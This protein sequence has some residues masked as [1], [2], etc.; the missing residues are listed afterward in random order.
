M[1]KSVTAEIISIGDELLYGQI[2]DTNSR[3]ISEELDKIGIRV[4]RRTTVGDDKTTLLEAFGAASKKADIILMTGGLGPTKD[5]LTK[6]TLASFFDSELVLVPQALEDLSGL[7]ARRGRELTLTNR[8]QAYL[9]KNCTYIPNAV[10]TAA[11]MWFVEKGNTWMSMP[12]VPHEMRY[13]MEHEVIPRLMKSYTLPVIYHKLV[14]TVGIGE[15]WLSDIIGDWEN[16][17]PDHIR[18]AYLPSLGEVKLR[19]TG[20]GTDQDKIMLE[21][22]EQINRL[23]PLISTYVYGFNNDSLASVI[24]HHLK[25]RGQTLAIA[26]SCS[27]GFISHQITSIAGSSTYFNGSMVPYHNKFKSGLLGI[28][29]ATLENHGAVS[30]ATVTEMAQQVRLKFD[31]DF[32]LASS[33]IAGPGG[34]SE[35][36]PVGLVWIGCCNGN[37]CITKKLQLTQDRS[38]NIQLTAVAALNLLREMIL[39]YPE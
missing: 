35:T 24:G 11:G 26:E 1:D 10:G 5:D 19:L 21:V 25:Q 17:L 39:N 23:L 13:L 31:A 2:Q 27:G 38:V 14:R 9:P 3:W 7:F 16:Q 8:E 30:E 12:G 15:S 29:S 22:D 34:G 28:N 4:I 36:K 33:G 6:Q 37:D 32:G 20:F 18:L